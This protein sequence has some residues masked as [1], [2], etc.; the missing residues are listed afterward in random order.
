MEKTQDKI[1]VTFTQ[2][3]YEALRRLVFDFRSCKDDDDDDRQWTMDDL[4]EQ[5]HIAAQLV[6]LLEDKIM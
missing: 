4:T 3:D 1:Q 5:A 2:D 6:E